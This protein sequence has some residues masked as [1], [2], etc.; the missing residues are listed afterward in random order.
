M[1]A[2]DVIVIGLGAMGSAA[3]YQLAG[4]GARVIGIDRFSPPHVMGSTHGDTRI[5]RQAVGEGQEYVPLVRRSHELWRQ[6]EVEANV[7]L[8]TDCGGLILTASSATSGQH[9]A[10]DFFRS[11]VDAARTFH[12]EHEVLDTDGIRARFPQFHL[13]E[14][15]R[16]YYEPSA[17]FV[18]PERA[19]ST[20]LMLAE[21]RGAIMRRDERVI[22]LD[23]TEAAVTVKTTSRTYEAAQ[24]IITAGPWIGTFFNGDALRG[25]FPVYR[26]V[27]HWFDLSGPIEEFEP[28]R[29]PVFIWQFGAGD[30]DAFYGFPAIDGAI[31]GMKV[32]DEQYVTQANPD[33]LDRTVTPGEPLAMFDRCVA[34][35]IRALAPRAVRSAAC[36]Y[37]VTPGHR[38]IIDRHPEHDNVIFASPCSGH[39]FKH[40]AAIGEVLSELVLDG[41]SRIDIEA[42]RLDRLTT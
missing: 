10:L 11:T 5:T 38:F 32:A 30:D 26:Q 4:R 24:V 15:H 36:V 3:L 22:Q 12:I 1:E 8:F 35:R 9:G 23:P 21:R 19:V 20:Q 34:G 7:D 17:G 39:G 13:T 14:E 27:L 40:S 18:R 37:T 6:I 42:F 29:M 28:G 16:G 25:L 41:T 33:D 2:A 31:G